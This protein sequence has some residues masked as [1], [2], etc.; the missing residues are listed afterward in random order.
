MQELGMNKVLVVDDEKAIVKLIE[1]N[2]RLEDFHVVT[3]ADGIEALERLREERPDLIILDIMMP[4]M[5]GWEVLR[6]VRED[7]EFMDV[8]VVVLTARTHNDDVIQG[9]QL[10]ADEYITK[11]FSPIALVKMVQMVLE[12]TPE[13]RRTRREREIVR[14]QLLRSLRERQED[15]TDISSGWGMPG[16]G[17][18]DEEW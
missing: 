2:L 11:P 3:A 12:R 13:E 5:D 4:R 16:A 8:P 6:Q 15:W 1:V 10:G 7:Q 14:A 17:P 9:W 18:D